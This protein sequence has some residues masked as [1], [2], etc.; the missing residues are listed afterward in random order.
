[1]VGLAYRVSELHNRNG[2]ENEDCERQKD[3]AEALT[4]GL[5]V[6]GTTE[7]LSEQNQKLRTELERLVV[8]I[9]DA[10]DLIHRLKDHRDDLLDAIRWH[11]DMIQ[12]PTR[13]DRRLWK[14]TIVK[15]DR[16]N[17]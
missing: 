16:D 6:S 17:S 15:W 12:L 5:P 1:M 9:H 14:H 2:D 4:G 10:N 3:S 7:D 8:L 11:R 13:P